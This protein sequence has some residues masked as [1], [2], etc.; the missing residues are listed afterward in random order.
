[1]TILITGAGGFIGLNVAEHLLGAGHD[2]LALTLSPLPDAARAAFA[3]LPGRLDEAIGDVT[4]GRFVAGL[5]ARCRPRAVLHAAAIT[6]GPDADPA[7]AATVLD[8]NVA[9]TA[10]LLLQAREA[11]AGRV[12]LTSSSAVYGDA[13][14]EPAPLDE[15]TPTRPATLYGISKLAAER[16]VLDHR[17]AFGADAVVT[18]LT[19]IFGPWEHDTGV[20]DTLSPPLQIAAAALRGAPVVL[21]RGGLRDWTHAADVGRALATL[22]TT[23]KPAQPLYNLCCGG[24]WHPE[25]LCRA[26]QPHFPDW[27]WRLAEAGEPPSIAYNDALDRPRRSP[28]QAAR[29]TTE[30]GA[31]FRAPQAAAAAYADWWAG[32]GQALLHRG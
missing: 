5:L 8:V 25:L 23:A 19:A 2:V 3:A 7:R 10:R 9:A 6:A 1:M 28:P 29:F 24:T 20:R 32:H 15:T 11:G 4:D 13:P 21:A 12:V 22:L 17:Q 18:R 30:F 16:I 31:V 26:L 14:F 27:R